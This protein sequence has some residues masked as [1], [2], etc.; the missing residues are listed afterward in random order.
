M[1]QALFPNLIGLGWDVVRTPTWSTNVQ[2]TVSGREVRTSYYAAPIYKYSLG[3]NV[4]RQGAAFLEWQTLMGFYNA[5]GGG[6]DSFLFDDPNDDTVTAMAFG[7]GD[8]VTT[9][10][11]LKRTLGG[12]AEPIY[13]T[14]S[15]PLIYNNAVLQTVGLDYT[16]SASGLVLF[17]MRP[18]TPAP[19][20]VV[21]N[22]GFS[23][24]AA[25]YYAKVSALNAA[26]ETIGSAES[27]GQVC[28]GGA[29]K[30]TWSWTAV[31]GATAYSIYVGTA[32]G[33]ENT[34]LA[35]GN[36]LTIVQ[37]AVYGAGTP[38]A[39]PTAGLAPVA[40]NPLTWTGTYYW[41][42]RFDADAVDF[43]NFAL[44]FWEAKKVEFLTV[45]GPP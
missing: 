24:P 32:P 1:S 25:T 21:L 45:K 34:K 13:N 40:S 41:R 29:S 20:G 38:L 16:I 39:V 11:Q 8:G 28:T 18:P 31:T 9:A 44:N 26:G 19:T 30:I 7:T 27:L 4:L 15:V 33:A 14:N 43:T 17:V 23:L 6:Y 2:R 22:G 12:F 5:R 10:F 42:C 3:Y 36:V 37:T 35:L